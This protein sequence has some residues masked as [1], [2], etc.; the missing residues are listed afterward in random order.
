MYPPGHT[1]FEVPPEACFSAT[2]SPALAHWKYSNPVV[3]YGSLHLFV[4][5]DFSIMC[6]GTVHVGM[7]SICRDRR[8]GFHAPRTILI[9]TVEIVVMQDWTRKNWSGSST[10]GRCSRTHILW[11]NQ[12]LSAL[13]TL[14]PLYPLVQGCT[15]SCVKVHEINPTCNKSHLSVRQ[16]CKNFRLNWFQILDS[17]WAWLWE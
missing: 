10:I 15:V 17:W 13:R 2:I 14:S 4:Q 6:N 7:C 11:R 8:P 12:A 5:S 9:S 16:K 3:N 1:W